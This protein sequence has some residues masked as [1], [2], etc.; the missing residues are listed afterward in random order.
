MRK[1]D[2][3][4]RLHSL[5]SWGASSAADHEVSDRLISKHG[6][7]VLDKARNGYIKGNKK[8]RLRV[9]LSLGL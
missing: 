9:S 8:S 1:N 2:E 5:R 6:R 4:F 7:W 3:H